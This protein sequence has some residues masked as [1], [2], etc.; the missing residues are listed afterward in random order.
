MEDWYLWALAAGAVVVTVLAW[1]VPRAPMWVALASL[2]F[3]TSG[4]YHDAGLPYGAAFG[5][6]TNFVVIAAL[7]AYAVLLYELVFWGCFLLMLMIDAIY[8]SGAV[9]SHSYFAIGLE[10][11]NWLALLSVGA[12]GM[13]DRAGVGLAWVGVFRARPRWA[14]AVHLGSDAAL[15]HLAGRASHKADKR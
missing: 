9:S 4:W 10:L 15:V 14:G 5:A 11:A 7:Y 8:L 13:A 1:R 3:I 2:S 12:A 6:F